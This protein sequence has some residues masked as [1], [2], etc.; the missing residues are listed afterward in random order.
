ME[1]RNDN[2][3]PHICVSSVFHPWL[4]NCLRVLRVS[5]VN[6]RYRA[7]AFHSRRL[8]P[9]HLPFGSTISTPLP[10]SASSSSTARPRSSSFTSASTRP[11]LRHVQ[12][13]L[14]EP[15]AVGAG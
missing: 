15:V 11:L 4:L 10:K 5:V 7:I 1:H 2:D 14:V 12:Q 9:L 8:I 13:P 6:L 3:L